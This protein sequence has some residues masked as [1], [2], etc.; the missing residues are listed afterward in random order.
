MLIFITIG[1]VG[2]AVLL[3]AAV[4]GELFDLLDGGVSGTGLGAGLSVFGASGVLVI[5]LALPVVV[6]YVV[7]IAVGIV[8]LVCVQTVIRR[9][10]QTEDTGANDPTGLTGVARTRVSREGGE[11][12][13]DGPYELETRLATSAEDIPAG[14]LVRVVSL[15]G[16]RV[17]VEALDLTNHRKD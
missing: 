1:I 17:R 16:S 6:A 12:S 14:G 13:L 15:S 11:V 7:A 10:K 5:A 3:L 2:L 9:L 4:F 8:T